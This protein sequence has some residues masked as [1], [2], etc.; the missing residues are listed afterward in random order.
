MEQQEPAMVM[1]V[2]SCVPRPPTKPMPLQIMST[3]FEAE[4]V[5]L[6]PQQLKDL[7]AFAVE[8]DEQRTKAMAEDDWCGLLDHA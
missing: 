3:T 2:G 1:M 7:K 5:C 6:V 4:G 8:R